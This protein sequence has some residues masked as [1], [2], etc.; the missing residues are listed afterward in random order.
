MSIQ[1]TINLPN[2][3]PVVSGGVHVTIKTAD[4]PTNIWEQ[5]A[6]TGICEAVRNAASGA[7]NSDSWKDDDIVPDDDSEH[8]ATIQAAT[9]RMMQARLN[10][11]EAGDWTARGTGSPA[12]PLERLPPSF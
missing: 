2:E 6:N 4:I 5:A 7:A 1:I 11:M 12:D 3:M 8:T 9:K 10:K